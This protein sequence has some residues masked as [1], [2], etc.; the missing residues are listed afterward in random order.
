MESKKCF[1]SK[2]NIQ[3]NASNINIIK[4]EF[5]GNFLQTIKNINKKEKNKSFI[6]IF[7]TY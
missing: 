1:K 5:R 2:Q 4:R 3:M 7:F 6:N